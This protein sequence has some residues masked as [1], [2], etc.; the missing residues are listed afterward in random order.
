MSK[1]DV[2]GA[3]TLEIGAILKTLAETKVNWFT[4]FGDFYRFE[5]KTDTYDL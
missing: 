1:L 2:Q 5:M 3:Y 4:E